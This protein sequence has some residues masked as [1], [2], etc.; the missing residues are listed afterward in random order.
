[1]HRKLV[2]KDLSRQ[3][4]IFPK[5]TGYRC[6]N[7]G[8]LIQ[9]IDMGEDLVTDNNRLSASDEDAELHKGKGQ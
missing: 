2:I 1:M 4:T 3:K 8:A 6:Y 7:L 9:F 5:G